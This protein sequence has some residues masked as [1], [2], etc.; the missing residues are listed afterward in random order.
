MAC[1]CHNQRGNEL[2][3][4]FG[5]I[6]KQFFKTARN[7]RI[8]D[9]FRS[10]WG[11]Y[12]YSQKRRL[13]QDLASFKRLRSPARHHKTRTSN[14]SFR[15]WH[16]RRRPFETLYFNGFWNVG[17]DGSRSYLEVGKR[18]SC[19]CI[20][21]WKSNFL[22]C[23]RNHDCRLDPLRP[24]PFF[25]RWPLGRNLAAIGPERRGTIFERP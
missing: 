6:A 4:R 25:W 11:S 20:F 17:L 3:F 19:V 15:R 13:R 14:R 7:S 24:C 18:K 9:L 5:P 2:G 8:F 1:L 16:D 22:L 10:G 12:Y 21:H 23:E